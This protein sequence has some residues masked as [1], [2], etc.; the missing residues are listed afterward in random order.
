MVFRLLL[1]AF[2]GFSGSAAWAQLQTLRTGS[3]LVLDQSSLL[4]RSKLGQDILELERA[5]QAAILDAG[6]LVT[7]ELET[8]EAELTELRKTLENDEFRML[9][10]AF[11][12]RVELARASQNAIDDAQLLRVE[13]RRREFF[14]SILPQLTNIIQKYGAAAIID[15]R[16]VLLFDKNLDITLETIELLD[17]AYAENPDMI[18]LGN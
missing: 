13:T 3:I 9:A 10:D 16:S 4:T 11:N 18:D 7:Q 8:E 1:I 5:E 14:Q 2:L 17:E 12:D 6:Q 15:R